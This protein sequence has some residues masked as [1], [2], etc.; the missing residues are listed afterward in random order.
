MSARDAPD[1][2]APPPPALATGRPALPVVGRSADAP[3]PAERDRL[4]ALAARLLASEPALAA[5]GA[6]GP[7]VAP[8]VGPGPGLLF[9][10]HGEIPLIGGRGDS[11]LQYRALLLAGDGDLVVLGGARSAAFEAYC[12]D[13]LGLGSPEVHVVPPGAPGRVRTVARGLLATPEALARILAV[14]RRH[15]ALNVLPYIGTGS[16]WRLAG[17]IAAQADAEV[18]VAASPPR[19]TQR[20]NDKLWFAERVVEVLGRDALPP[21]YHAFGPAALAARVAALARRCERVVIKVP[22]SAGSAGNLAL[23]ADSVRG[24]SLAKLR[25]RILGLLRHLGWRATYPLMVGVWECPALASPSAQLWVPLRADGPPVLEGLF[26]QVVEGP[27]GEFVGAVPCALPEPWRARLATEALRLA[28][29]FQALGYFG[30]CSFDA[31]VT[32]ADYGPAAL[33]WIECNGR[34]GGT[35]IPMTLANRLAGDW[36]R[37]YLRVV[38]RVGVRTRA[39]DLVSVLEAF[40][41]R[42]LRRDRPDRGIVVLTPGGLEGGTGAH[43]LVLAASAAEAE[44]D[45][46]TV[47]A[48]LGF[49]REPHA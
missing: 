10:D 45:V 32:G 38:Q 13:T 31:I 16:V 5:T 3:A 2:S 14:A 33:H 41:P 18:R 17:L 36:T 11:A 24:L 1:V 12:R 44:R 8:G 49:D 22:D 6:F 9:E 40:G 15:G 25:M 29:L 30:R 47:D 26:D 28:W 35:S 46:A 27:G 4:D 19:L 37:R 23:A 42:L 48:L 21:S 34:W 39:R 43:F 20:V 7:R